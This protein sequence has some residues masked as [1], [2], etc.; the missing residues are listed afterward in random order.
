MWAVLSH[1]T[2]IDQ[3]NFIIGFSFGLHPACVSA[4]A[5]AWNSTF[6]PIE[7]TR[8][9]PLPTQSQRLARGRRTGWIYLRAPGDRKHEEF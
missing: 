3:I 2:N 6:I 8:I 5:Y 1:T 4:N 7:L 9:L